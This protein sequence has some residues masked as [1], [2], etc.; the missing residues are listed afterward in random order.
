MDWEWIRQPQARGRD[1]RLL[2]RIC[3]KLYRHGLHPE[4]IHAGAIRETTGRHHSATHRS[5]AGHPARGRSCAR[6][7]SWLAG[8]RIRSPSQ[9]IC[10]PV[11]YRTN[12]RRLQLRGQ[13][14][15]DR[16]IMAPP[17]SRLSFRSSR[18]GR[19]SNTRYS[20]RG[21]KCVNNY[22]VW[23]Q[24]RLGIRRGAPENCAPPRAHALP[25]GRLISS[26]YQSIY[27]NSFCSIGAMGP[28]TK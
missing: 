23:P 22:D 27:R 16:A 25:F 28:G 7:V 11:A 13:L 2:A 14:R 5:P 21:K 26:R 9:S 15:I 20:R 1:Y 19:T 8:R 4:A 18:I 6:Q 12:A 24:Y 17:D 3:W 10:A